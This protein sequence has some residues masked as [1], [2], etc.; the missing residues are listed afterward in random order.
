[1]RAIAT[2]VIVFGAIAVTYLI[3]WARRASVATSDASAIFK[4]TG[5]I[6]ATARRLYAEQ[7]LPDKIR[8]SHRQRAYLDTN[9]DEFMGLYGAAIDDEA[10][11]GW[12][13]YLAHHRAK[14]S[15]PTEAQGNEAMEAIISV[16]V[17]K[18]GKIFCES[19]DI[20]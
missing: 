13:S 1:M 17:L 5:S 16:S 15:S 18:Y 11:R 2:L 7:S 19:R 8:L 14:S 12:Q 10:V 3:H 9:H 20:A 6:A 4:E